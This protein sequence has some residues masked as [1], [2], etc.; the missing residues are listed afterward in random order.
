MGD[1]SGS[2]TLSA[3]CM[4]ETCP[5]SKAILEKREHAYQ[6]QKGCMSFHLHPLQKSRASSLQGSTNSIRHLDRICVKRYRMHW[7]LITPGGYTR[8]SCCSCRASSARRWRSGRLY[9]DWRHV[10][11]T[12]ADRLA[13]VFRR[14]NPRPSPFARDIGFVPTSKSS[15]GGDTGGLEI[16]LV[17]KAECWSTFA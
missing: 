15:A 13:S 7:R 1:A 3:R 10:L 9:V 12:H 6:R 14:G 8:T 4:S 11:Q 16:D 5:G 2:R 17:S